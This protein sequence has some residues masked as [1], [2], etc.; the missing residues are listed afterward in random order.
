MKLNVPSGIVLRLVKRIL[1]PGVFYCLAVL[2]CVASGRWLPLAGQLTDILAL[3]VGIASGA[4][5]YLISLSLVRRKQLDWLGYRDTVRDYTRVV[6]LPA[7]KILKLGFRSFYEEII[8]RGTFQYL[9]IFSVSERRAVL[10]GILIVAVL[11]TVRHWYFEKLNARNLGMSRMLEFLFFSIVLGVA[12]AVTDS[13]MLVIG[14]HWARNLLI[15][16]GC[17]P[18]GRSINNIEPRIYQARGIQK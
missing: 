1:E 5:L 9:V 15:Q 2:L 16:A 7:G 10:L 11:F 17:S 6:R 12:Y 3:C 14:I 4:V 18:E 8:W 13:I